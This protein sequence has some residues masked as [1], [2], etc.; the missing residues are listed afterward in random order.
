[1][2][3]ELRFR[4]DGSFKIVQ[5]TDLHLTD[6]TE[7][8]LR[9][10]K[11]MEKILKEELPDLVVLTG[12]MVCGEKN[13][14][15]IS[16]VIETMKQADIPWAAAFGN[17]DAE[18]GAAKE[19]LLKLQQENPLCLSE[20]GDP[21]ISGIGNYCVEII[22]NNSNKPAWAL[23]FFDSGCLNNNPKVEGYDFI[24]RDQIHWYINQSI[25]YR[26]KFGNVPA[27][28]FFHIPLQ[29]YNEVWELTTC[30]GEKNEKVCCSNQ[31]SGLFS[32]M[33][34]MGDVKG[35][36]VGHDHINDYWGELFGIKLCY[37]RAT[38]Y[39][40]YGKKDFLHG[41][42]VILLREGQVDFET[43]V[44]LEDGNIILKPIEHVP[45]GGNSYDV[46]TIIN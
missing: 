8:D 38:G 1:M 36:F 14:I 10:I 44:R 4:K 30:Y 25:Q 3:R 11:L 19:V 9:T 43:W 22:R 41:A 23:Y 7:I 6:G 40:T 2:K 18:E 31:N 15:F 5:F 24:K 29:E 28:S 34:E 27:L 42:R 33:L 32:S 16:Q 39:N 37:G 12:D 17:H 45:E 21:N 35:V 26:N 13:Y 20:A 46:N